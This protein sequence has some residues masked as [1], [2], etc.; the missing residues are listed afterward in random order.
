[1]NCRG[2]ELQVRRVAACKEGSPLHPQVALTLCRG[3]RLDV[4]TTADQSQSRNMQAAWRA[5]LCK[6]T[7]LTMYCARWAA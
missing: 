1:M 7:C 6:L 5:S 4:E 3:S 2:G